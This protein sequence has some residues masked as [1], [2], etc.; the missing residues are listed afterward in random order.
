V[1]IF[2]ALVTGAGVWAIARQRHRRR[3]AQMRIAHATETERARIAHDLHDDLGAALTEISMLA[4]TAERSGAPAPLTAIGDKT[5]GLVEALDSIVWSVNPG[6][7]SVASFVDYASGYA[8]DF[9][10][11]A[12][13]ACRLDIAPDLPALGLGARP[14]HQLFLALK[15]ALNNAVRH[16]AATEVRLRMAVEGGNRFVVVVED[17][18]HGFDT[19]HPAVG[20]GLAGLRTR[21]AALGG[22]SVILSKIGAGTIV[23]LEI[24]TT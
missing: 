14:R 6:Y 2:V 21:L 12:G 10:E 9:L 3:V 20:M 18:G 17:N 8:R 24:P 5:R 11:S 22:E 4:T 15:E 19:G 1:V 16:S 23:R 13:L 7:D